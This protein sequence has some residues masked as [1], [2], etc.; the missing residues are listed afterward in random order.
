MK[1]ILVL[2]DFSDNATRSAEAAVLIGARLHANIILCNSFISQPVLSEYGGMPWPVEQLLWEDDGKEKLAYL[3]EGLQK[4]VKQLPANSHYPSI[5]TRQV[6]GSL[7]YEVKDIVE[8]DKVEMIVMGS[9]SGK[10]LDHILVGSDTA[11]VINHTNRPVLVVPACHP[12]TKIKNVTLA[13]IFD[14]GGLKAVHYLT[15]LGR[16]FNFSIN[17]V[18][19]AL[20][21]DKAMPDAIKNTFMKQ[22]AK[23]NYPHITYHN[24][25]GKELANRL[26]DFCGENCSD[27]LALVHDQHS[28][29]SRLFKQSHSQALLKNQALPVMIIPAQIADE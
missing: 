4:F 23:F 15:R 17:I 29:L 2:T 14:E 3:R 13:T 18:H 19:I 28:F 26:N 5:D 20:W 9:Q 24:I 8:N 16:V 21:G 11:A 27:V 7:G 25:S 22:V 10:A 6:I 1:K 12:L